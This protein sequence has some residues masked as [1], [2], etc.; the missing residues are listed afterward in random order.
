[1]TTIDRAI[2]VVGTLY[3]LLRNRLNPSGTEEQLGE[4]ELSCTTDRR[5]VVLGHE[6]IAGYPVDHGEVADEAAMLAL[7]TFGSTTLLVEPTFVAP[8]DS[9]RRVDDPGWRWYCLS[10]HGTTLADW[11]RRPLAE[12]L[13]GLAVSGHTHALADVVGLS[14]ALAGKQVASA[15]LSDLS[16]VYGSLAYRGSVIAGGGGAQL[17]EEQSVQMWYHVAS[18]PPL[19]VNGVAGDAGA[20][21]ALGDLSRYGRTVR[22]STSGNSPTW[23][24]AESAVAFAGGATQYLQAATIAPYDTGLVGDLTLYVLARRSAASGTCLYCGSAV[25]N[26]RVN[27]YWDAGSII[28]VVGTSGVAAWP[29]TPT[30]AWTLLELRWRGTSASLYADGVLVGSATA[31]HAHN[32][33]AWETWKLGVYNG[34]QGLDLYLRALVLLDGGASEAYCDSVRDTLL[35]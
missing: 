12:A 20:V 9:C 8:G 10:G 17:W 6:P 4:Q 35:P 14:S 22:Q 13:S 28:C 29:Y 25:D 11:E 21:V 30:T 7:H 34:T 32:T 26:N 31:T 2:A 15:V 23:S 18:R 1:M 19:G 33:A 3:G 27:L 24:S 16:D 5:L